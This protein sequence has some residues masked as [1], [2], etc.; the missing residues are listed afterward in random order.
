MRNVHIILLGYNTI[1]AK[2]GLR[3]FPVDKVVLLHSPDD[4]TGEGFGFATLAET[5]RGEL[6]SMGIEEVDMHVIDAFDLYSIT[7]TILKVASD[8]R[9]L[10]PDSEFWVNIT[11]GTN[12]MAGAASA[13]SYFIGATLYYVQGMKKDDGMIGSSVKCF[14]TPRV[15][16]IN[17]LG[18]MSKDILRF[19]AG[20]DYKSNG[21]KLLNRDVANSLGISVQNASYH[22]RKLRDDGLLKIEK[23]VA[24]R[25]GKVNERESNISLTDHGRLIATWI[26]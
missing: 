26:S 3:N 4:V 16:D 2:V 5:F 6:S 10:Y 15:P 13:A 24:G 23:T 11:S 12:L 9:A 18:K 22:L 8:E 21:N 20:W 17:S 7:E 1:P 14:S 19:V 25:S